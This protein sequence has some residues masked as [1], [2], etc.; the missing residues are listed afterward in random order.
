MVMTQISSAEYNLSM[1]HGFFFG[2]GGLIKDKSKGDVLSKG[3]ALVQGLWFTTQ[4]LARVHQHLAVT[5]LEV[6]TLVFAVVNI[7]IWCLWWNKPLDV[8]RPMVVGPPKSL[9]EQPI[10]PVRISRWDGFGYA[11]LG[12]NENHDDY[13]MSTIR[14][15]APL[16]PHSGPQP[17]TITFEWELWELPFLRVL[18]LGPFTVLH[19]TFISPPPQRCGYGGPA[20]W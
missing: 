19:G 7:S 18:C 10:T 2:M 6:A 8:Q 9:D 1:T 13:M 14:S 12:A 4:C 11:I 3:V 5:G 20:P 16:Y 15:L 17:R